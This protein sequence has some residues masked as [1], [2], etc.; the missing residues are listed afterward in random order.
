LN[1]ARIALTTSILDQK[2][3]STRKEIDTRQRS[4][5]A[6]INTLISGPA[7]AITSS[8]PGCS[9]IFA[10]RARPPIGSNVMSRVRTPNRRAADGTS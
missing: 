9:G 3:S 2:G 5:T 10:I 8:C 7:R 4:K 6:T 1:N